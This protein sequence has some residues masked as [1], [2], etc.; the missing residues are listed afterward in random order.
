VVDGGF[1]FGEGGVEEWQGRVRRLAGQGTIPLRACW[2]I[3]KGERCRQEPMAPVELARHLMDAALEIDVQ[4][5]AGRLAAGA[6]PGKEAWAEVMESRRRWFG[7]VADIARR[8]PGGHL[9]FTKDFQ[10]SELRGLIEGR[11]RT[12]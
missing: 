6:K 3:H 12:G 9:W 10:A 7:W 11:T 1:R 8:C 4:R 5:K 2:R